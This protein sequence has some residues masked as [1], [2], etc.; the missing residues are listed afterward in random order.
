MDKNSPN[1]EKPNFE[2]SK[3]NLISQ[4][5]AGEFDKEN[6]T[7]PVKKPN[8]IKSGPLPNP[9][10]SLK[11]W[12]ASGKRGLPPVAYEIVI[13]DAPN[14]ALEYELY[15]GFRGQVSPWEIEQRIQLLEKGQK[16]Q[17]QRYTRAAIYYLR[18]KL[19]EFVV[20]D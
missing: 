6:A 1:L 12:K 11:E 2:V 19:E 3:L 4:E 9:P 5:R 17:N 16:A 8:L 13:K 10:P 15:H 14:N 20:G 7:I 18:K